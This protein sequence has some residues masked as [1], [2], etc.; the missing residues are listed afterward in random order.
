MNQPTFQAP[1]WY[2]TLTLT[3]RI[4]SLR[5]VEHNRSNVEI[6]TER[7]QRRMQHWR[8]QSPFTTNSYWNQRLE[9]D[10]MTEKE[11][12][13]FLGEPSEAIR[14]RFSSTPACLAE[15]E[16]AFARPAVSDTHTLSP[17]EILQGE[18]AAGFLYAVEPLISQGC[19]Q[20]QEEIQLLSQTQSQL[21]FDPSN[22]MEILGAH[23]PEQLL[24]MVNRTMV[25]ELNVARLQG[26]LQGNTSEER[27]QSFLEQLR[28]REQ[29][30]ALFQEYPV[31]ARQIQ[32]CI[33]RWVRFSL[34]FL[35][36]LCTDWD[37]IRA[38]FSRER[39]PGLL[40][41]LEW[42]AGDSHR[43]GRS[44]LIA[45]F[46]CSG[47]QV[48]YKPRSLAV[49]IHFQEL[50]T[51]LNQR[52]TH[53]PFKTLKVLDRDSYGW[54][55]FVKTCDCTTAQ[56]VERFYERQGGYLALLYALEATD[57][58][59]D[60]LI[61]VGG[62]PILVD[63]E[64]LFHPRF[65]ITTL[66]ESDLLANNKMAY[67]VLSVGLLPQRIWIDAESEGIDMSGLGSMEGQLS[68][69]QVPYWQR[70]G[71]DEMQL[72]RKQMEMLGSDNRPI[73]NGKKIDVLAYADSL[74][75]GFIKLYQLLLQH[76]DELLAENGPLAHFAGDQVRVIIRDT[77]TYAS[78]LAESFH[79]DVLRDA[80]D[81]DRLFDQLWLNIEQQ[82]Y[83]AQVIAAERDDLW[84]GDIPVFT[85]RP[86]SRDIWS[87]SGEQIA[88]FSEKSGMTLV[89]RRLQQLN[90]ADLEQQ[91]WF[92]R[93]SL[94]T[95]I[96]EEEQEQWPAYHLKEPQ[97][98][99]SHEQLLGAAQAIGDRLD[100]LALCS[101]QEASWIG[102]NLIDEK[103]WTFAPLG[104][105][106]YEG[107][108]GIIL[109]LAYLGHITDKN[110]YT[111]LAKAALKTLQRQVESQK[112][113]IASIGSFEGWGG[114][115]YTLTQL[116]IIWDDP[117]LL[118]QAES[119]VALISSLITEDEQLDIISGSA[120]CIGSLI[121]LYYCKPSPNTLAAAIQCGDHLIAKARPMESGI[122]WRLDKAGTKPLTGF[123]HGSAG[124]AWAL[125]KLAA[126][127]GEERFRTA[128][129]EAI[130]YER[131]LFSHELGNWLDLRDFAD[132]VL[133]E[134]DNQYTCMT[135]W[136]HGAPGIGLARL[137]SLPYLDDAE[138]RTEI[139]TALKTTLSHGFGRN[140]SLCHG[141][142]GNLEL[143]LQASQNLDDPYWK[144]QVDRLAAIILE[145]I[146]Q[147]G[148]MCGVPLGVETPGLM[149]GLAGIGYQL[150]RLAEPERVS[151]VLVLEPPKLDSTVIQKAE[152]AM[153]TR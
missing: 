27:F 89:Q 134:K 22:V 125:L 65:D 40:T 60:N 146:E 67:S 71:T 36:H 30:L 61:A 139:N 31:L 11:L 97:N 95:L 5:A 116:S 87:S 43:G 37:D 78:L 73:L 128:A 54:V 90:Q 137:G 21:P 50:L 86:N 147:H 23:L 76:R 80:L 152:K 105:D 53:P 34:E 44:V 99:A 151:S 59:S 133:K 140:H 68:P 42:G 121:N 38:T 10:G 150:L 46:S 6:N 1:S 91:L 98:S 51:W 131:S 45:K 132:T 135:A 70:I 62:H 77:Y 56:E 75:A 39:E 29:A 2:Q 109:F 24:H 117:K 100:T 7:A 16:Q 82:P 64:S 101:K 4:A 93:G 12:L 81:R 129:L 63:L 145:S 122:G 28:Q 104:M 123:S 113:F 92:I 149:T 79:P 102:L 20:L 108:P 107:L 126:L 111:D 142:L 96:T 115:I 141:D 48:V 118:A 130:A 84:Q 106:L 13:N 25:L 66:G 8:E 9:L 14:N 144:T 83:L 3:E 55:E 136:C 74:Q 138:I 143:L 49:D 119:L 26:L 114:I 35:Q 94:T 112:E 19:D 72:K 15:I 124:M 69:Y 47:F 58:H 85:T 120:G 153:T 57:F 110:R 127:T 17:P 148:W 41:A 88:D 32:I 33:D 103:H 18:E 52:G